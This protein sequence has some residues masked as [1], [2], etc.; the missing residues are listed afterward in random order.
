MPIY[1][2]WNKAGKM[3]DPNKPPKGWSEKHTLHLE[4]T[5]PLGVS[6]VE[7][8]IVPGTSMDYNSGND[9]PTKWTITSKSVTGFPSFVFQRDV[10]SPSQTK[11]EFW[12]SED[13]NEIGFAVNY[14]EAAMNMMRQ[15]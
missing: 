4:I 11:Y 5:M 3:Y 6:N 1:T 8:D 10:T 13:K 7:R 14:S 12:I 9:K 2:W 15:R